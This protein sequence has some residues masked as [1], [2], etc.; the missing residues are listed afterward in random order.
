MDI[1]HNNRCKK[2]QIEGYGYLIKTYQFFM[3]KVLIELM[4]R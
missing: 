1:I 3:C 4:D 2:W